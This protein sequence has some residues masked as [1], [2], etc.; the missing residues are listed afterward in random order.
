M[1]RLSYIAIALLISGVFSCKEKQ[2]GIEKVIKTQHRY[3]DF[4]IPKTLKFAGETIHLNDIDVRERYERELIVNAYYH[5]STFFLI[6]RSTRWLPLIEKILKEEGLPEDF[7]Y[8][9]VAESGLTQANSYAGARGFWQFL[10]PTAKDY[11]LEINKHVDERYHIEKSTR[12]ACKYLLNAKKDLGSWPLAAA[13]YNR[14]K[15]GISVNLEQQYVTNY[16]DLN[17][18]TETA[19]YF[20]RILALKEIIENPKKYNFEIN[21]SYEPYKTRKLNVK[22]D[23][24]NLS[25]WAKNMGF[26]KKILKKLNPWLI[27]NKLKLK[28]G[29]S[30]VILLPAKGSD[31]KVYSDTN[32]E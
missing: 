26:N 15:R 32:G 29:K 25:L 3:S 1:V 20:F 31:L 30:Y 28:D 4:E 9:A 24:D 6:K 5:S 12:A 11:G 2:T 18:N 19:R 22:E 7:K 27:S 13:A 21:R 8:L 10:S 23:I 14:G 17:L 16:F